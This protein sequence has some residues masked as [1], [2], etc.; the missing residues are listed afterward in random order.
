MRVMFSVWV[1]P[2]DSP[3]DGLDS[4]L[5]FLSAINTYLLLTLTRARSNITVI[6]E[7]DEVF[8]APTV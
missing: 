5:W 1:T 3:H 8:C 4:G 2:W 6:R 7:Q